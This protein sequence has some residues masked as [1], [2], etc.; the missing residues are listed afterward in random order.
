[1]NLR[2]LSTANYRN[3]DEKLFMEHLQQMFKRNISFGTGINTNDQNIQGQMVEVAD[4]GA[5]NAAITIT[6]NLGY[7]PQFY[8]VKYIS[9]ATQIFD[10][11]TPWTKTH[12]FL[13]S[14]TAHVKFRVFIH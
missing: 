11:G 7:V 1:M 8:D 14:S 9:L 6:H 12:I 10:F 13:A 3:M 2:R 4:S 5:A